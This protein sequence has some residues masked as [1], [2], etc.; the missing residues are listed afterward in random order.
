MKPAKMK[1][2][3]TSTTFRFLALATADHILTNHCRRILTMSL[4]PAE[5]KH[6]KAALHKPKRTK[7][8]NV[9]KVMEDRANNA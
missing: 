5:I 8:R 4:R 2:T 7:R 6:V 9:K 1:S 3:S